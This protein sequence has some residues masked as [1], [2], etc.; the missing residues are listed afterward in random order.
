MT[1][2]AHNGTLLHVLLALVVIVA[3]AR[4]LGALFR[5]LRQPSVIGEMA[6]GIVLGPSLLGHVAPELSQQLLPQSVAPI[7]GVVA[8]IG[9]ILF[10][11]L[12]GLELDVMQVR[13]NPRATLII[14]Q[15]SVVVPLALGV[16]V[17]AWLHP[18]A[19]PAGVPLPLFAG[20]CGVALSVTAFPVLARILTD[21]GL[22]KTPLG[23]L[24]LSCAALSDI[25]AWCL[26]AILVS[27]AESR[28]SGAVRTIGLTIAYVVLMVVAVR[29][30]ISRALRGAFG[31]GPHAS[32]LVLL[33][34]LASAL[35]T[36]WIGIHALFGA[37][38]FGAIVPHAA[39]VA[40]RLF[41]DLH[42]FVTILLLP[43]FFAFI[44]MRTQ[45]GLI[46]GAGEWLACAAIIA[47]A[48]VGKFGGTALAA[49]CV[50]EPWREAAKLGVLMN[51]R[52][53]MELVVLNVGLDLGVITPRL[54]AMMVIMALTTT[55]ATTPLL[56]VLRARQGA[57]SSKAPHAPTCAL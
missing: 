2:T 6:A 16:A 3:T 38:L 10:M 32:A 34:L 13:K 30:L 28:A 45:I 1:A 42:D 8:Q 48:C 47:V 26:L 36:E 24:S 56:H 15:A 7:I 9:V 4:I 35:A 11:F 46:H 54:F 37:F 53:L 40:R 57:G 23:V 22:Q 33:L 44:G 55:F 5:R 27:V 41:T 50:G 21:S 31:E 19:A 17:G 43:V 51:T 25:S 29:P 39:T 12:V 49:R 18:T 14:A 20:F 52:G